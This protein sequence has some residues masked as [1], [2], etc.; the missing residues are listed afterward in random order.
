SV[1]A[2]GRFLYGQYAVANRF[3]AAAPAVV[4]RVGDA[5]EA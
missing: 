3:A 5:L 2:P 4:R 1:S